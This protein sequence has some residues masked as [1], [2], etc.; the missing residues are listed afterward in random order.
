M[1]LYHVTADW[2][3]AGFTAEAGLIK[4]AA[5]ILGYLRGWQAEKA[6]RYLQ[7]R[8]FRLMKRVIR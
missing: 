2:F 5:P 8:G 7:G 6:V 4:E 3:V 1:I